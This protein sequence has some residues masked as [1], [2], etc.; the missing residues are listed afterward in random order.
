MFSFLLDKQ[1][2]VGLT[3]SVKWYNPHERQF[4]DYMT[5][6]GDAAVEGLGA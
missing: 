4:L 3:G 2:E 6:P 1:L 5:L